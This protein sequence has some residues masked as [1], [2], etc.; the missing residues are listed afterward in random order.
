MQLLAQS[1]HLLWAY[2]LAQEVKATQHR[3]FGRS[4]ICCTQHLTRFCN[5]LTAAPR[6]GPDQATWVGWVM[7]QVERLRDHH[8]PNHMSRP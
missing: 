5:E 7:L 4:C 1:D 6:S 2:L 8:I 3:I